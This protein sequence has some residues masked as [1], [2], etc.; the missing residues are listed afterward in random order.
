M[1][2]AADQVESV[3]GRYWHWELMAAGD[4][5]PYGEAFAN[6]QMYTTSPAGRA[7]RLIFVVAISQLVTCALAHFAAECLTKKKMKLQAFN[8]LSVCLLL[9][10]C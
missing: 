4:R 7:N 10:P 5:I 1:N 8:T 3:Q 9:S 6:L 2:A